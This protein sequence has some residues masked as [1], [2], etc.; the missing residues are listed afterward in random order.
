MP[1][2][3]I[4]PFAF[5]D[6]LVRVH[7]DEDG[8]PWF[9]AKDVCGV[10]DIEKYRDAVARMDEDERG[11]VIVDT[12]GGPQSTSTVSESG[13]YSLIFRSRKPEAKRFRK[14]VTGE[15]LPTLRKT[16]TYT[17]P[18]AVREPAPELPARTPLDMILKEL[19]S[20]IAGIPRR[21]VEKG[22]DYALQMAR[23]VGVI[24]P[25]ELAG[26]IV[27]SCRL[28]NGRGTAPDF[29][30]GRESALVREFVETACERAPGYEC[31]SR[32]LWLAFCAWC[33]KTHGLPTESCPSNKA[34][35]AVLMALGI[36]RKRIRP[37]TVFSGILPVEAWRQAAA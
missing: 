33:E 32:K 1:S 4:T 37:T 34:V 3:A 11:S 26:A 16:G 28:M 7:M 2:N 10:L 25:D 14:W 22:M 17:M 29:V 21:Q 35:S 15:V 6:A 5:D 8:N 30:G 20:E 24:D 18:G 23:V 27:E 9:V 12:L 13:L 31:G 19:Q 36:R